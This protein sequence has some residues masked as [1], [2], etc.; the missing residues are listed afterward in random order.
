MKRENAVVKRALMR[1]V[2]SSVAT[3]LQLKTYPVKYNHTKYNKMRCA[4][5]LYGCPPIYDGLP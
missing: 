4:Y 1:L 5:V 3:N 2:Q